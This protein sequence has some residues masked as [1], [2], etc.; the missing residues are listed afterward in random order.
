MYIGHKIDKRKTTLEL[1][2]NI[3]RI[4]NNS[5]RFT[6]YYDSGEPGSAGHMRQLATFPDLMYRVYL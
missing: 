2:L 5:G 4:T 6:E 1:F 3:E